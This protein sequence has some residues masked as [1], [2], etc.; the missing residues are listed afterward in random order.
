L[1][2]QLLLVLWLLIVVL[3][4]LLPLLKTRLSLL[5]LLWLLED[6]DVESHALHSAATRW[7]R[8]NCCCCWH[9]RSRSS[10][11]LQGLQ[12]GERQVGD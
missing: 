2:L 4:Q 3:W 9:C 7:S 10:R 6:I 12:L 11:R 5:L 1:L 8:S